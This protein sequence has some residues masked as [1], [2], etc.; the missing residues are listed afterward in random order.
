MGLQMHLGTGNDTPD[1]QIAAAGCVSI[2]LGVGTVVYSQSG[3][4]S[5][6]NLI[7]RELRRMG[8]VRPGRGSLVVNPQ[9]GLAIPEGRN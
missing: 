7:R 6:V 8:T 4:G 9:K 1:M 2:D 3:Q 5:F